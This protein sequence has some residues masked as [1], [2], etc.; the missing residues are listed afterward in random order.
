[1]HAVEVVGAGVTGSYISWKLA[2]RGW[3][4]VLRDVLKKPW[5]KVCTGLVSAKAVKAFPFLE[6]SILNVVH[7]ARIHAGSVEL[8]LERKSVAYVLD[9]EALGKDLLERAEAAGAR[10][11][12]GEPGPSGDGT[13][14]VGSDGALSKVRRDLGLGVP[15]WVV[16]VQVN[17]KGSFDN[18]VDVYFF[19]GCNFFAWVVPESEDRARVGAAS[20]GDPLPFLRK[21]LR[22][23]GKRSVRR[24]EGRPIPVDHPL[25][26]VVF[27]TTALVGDAVPHTKATT[28]GGIYYG[29]LAARSLADAVHHFFSTGSLAPYQRFHA[30]VIYPRLALHAMIRSWLLRSDMED[31]MRRAKDAGI[32]DVLS[33]YGDM[34]DPMFILNPKIW[35]TIARI[36][37]PLPYILRKRRQNQDIPSQAKALDRI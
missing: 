26:R 18:Y 17:V 32:E 16:G 28:G 24:V 21:V 36:F 23:L 12:L 20:S 15:R 35:W 13:V 5:K 34:D 14:L 30:R 31:L 6:E 19:P 29:L 2:E 1:M 4:V 25:K 9:R 11:I 37:S 7:G 3:S 10:V 22:T 33:R 8:F 27:G